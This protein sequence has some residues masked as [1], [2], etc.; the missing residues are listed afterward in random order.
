LEDVARALGLEGQLEALEAAHAYSEQAL[1]E[2]TERLAE[3][4]PLPD[5]PVDVVIL[6]SLARR[7]ASDESDLDSLVIAHG[8]PDSVKE[9]R[10]ILRA[11]DEIRAELQLGEPGATGMFGDVIA[12]PDLTERIGLDDDTNESHSRRIL[13]LEESV[14]VYKPS[15]H[16]A[17]LEA[18]IERYLADYTSPKQGVPRFLLNDVIR[19]W[20]TITVDYQAKRW[21]RPGDQK[22]GLRYLKLLISRKLGFAGTVASLFLCEEAT[23]EYFMN[24]F[25]KPPLVRL[26]QL[27]SRLDGVELDALRDVFVIANSFAEALADKDIRNEI[28]AVESLAAA[29][30]A[31]VFMKLRT[32]GQRLQRQ[33]ETIFFDSQLLAAKSKKY[34]SF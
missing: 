12:A 30:D 21:K 8:L 23:V 15:L 22:W 1:H 33:L 29:A 10:T 24:E 3:K 26:S 19:Y 28:T 7:E 31:G 20:R 13:V 6:G 4:A 11:V 25:K 5:S 32:E 16:D 27:A 9:T 14:S 2:I 17:L 18:I 34:L